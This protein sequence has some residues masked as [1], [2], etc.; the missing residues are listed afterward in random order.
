MLLPK[1]A[2]IVRYLRITQTTRNPDQ[3]YTDH[4]SLLLDNVHHYF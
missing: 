4:Q 1:A 2:P 3:D